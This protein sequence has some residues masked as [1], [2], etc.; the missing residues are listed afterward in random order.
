MS[1]DKKGKKNKFNIGDKVE[2]KPKRVQWE[3]EHFN[4]MC[5]VPSEKEFQPD[6]YSFL[7]N[8]LHAHLKQK[9][10]IGEVIGY[11]SNASGP[12]KKD[13]NR[14]EEIKGESCI[15]VEF[16]MKYGTVTAYYH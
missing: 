11:G 9:M 15:R 10:P 3:V 14:W 6:V 7:A 2:M 8:F 16:K 13:P 1:Y 4:E 12:S 5:M